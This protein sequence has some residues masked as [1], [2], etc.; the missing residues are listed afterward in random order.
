MRKKLA[1][2]IAV[3]SGFS[4]VTNASAQIP[5]LTLKQI[6]DLSK[7]ERQELE[8]RCLGVSHPTCTELKSESFKKLRDLRISLCRSGASQTGLYDQRKAAKE[9]RECDNLF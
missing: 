4:V 3:A 6:L 5:S 9:E 8:R 2:I 1:L 7:N